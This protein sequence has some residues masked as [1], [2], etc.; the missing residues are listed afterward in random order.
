MSDSFILGFVGH[1]H[2]DQ[3]ETAAEFEDEVLPLLT[4]HGARLIYRGRRSAGQ[5]GTLPLELHLIWF[6]T[7]SALDFYLT[8]PRRNALLERY[9]EVF[10]SKI[11]V[12]LDTVESAPWP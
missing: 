6:P 7:R 5:D 8:D 2:P 10:T 11:V 4:N 9:G 3:V 12:E 1:A